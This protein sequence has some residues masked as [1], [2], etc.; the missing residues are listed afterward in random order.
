MDV[1]L[2]SH[3][4]VLLFDGVCNLCNGFVQWVIER[5]PDGVFRFA[6]LQSKV[7]EE[8]L[9]QAGLADEALNSV[10]LYENGRLYRR[11]TAALRV[12]RRMAFPWYLL[13]AFKLAP[14]WLRDAVYD[15]IARHRYAWFGRRD[16]CMMPTPDLK[17]RFLHD[18]E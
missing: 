10:V 14:E 1:K 4:P 2:P 12:L 15:Y 16:E 18:T 8:I 9:Q 6:P 3:H 11:S 17:R 13:Y 7:G 5:D